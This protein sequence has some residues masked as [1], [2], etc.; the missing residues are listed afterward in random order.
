MPLRELKVEYKQYEA[1]TAL[2]HRFDKFLVDDRIARLVP[3]FLGK[4]FYKRKKIPVPVNLQAKD[5]AAELA[6]AARTAVLPLTHHGTCALVIAGNADMSPSD[7]A[8][9]VM[10]VAKVL[11]KRYPGGWKNIRSLHVKCDATPA[12]PIHISI[13]RRLIDVINPLRALCKCFFPQ[14]PPTPSALLTPTSP[15]TTAASPSRTS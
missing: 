5:L 13:G 10:E 2:V 6:K 11:E 8:D 14:L 7:A 3:K 1:K 9:N 12:V 15:R 4:P